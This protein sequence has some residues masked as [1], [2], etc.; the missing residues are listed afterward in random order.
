MERQNEHDGKSG[1]VLPTIHS[2]WLLLSVESIL[3]NLCIRFVTWVASTISLGSGRHA[4]I[5]YYLRIILN[6]SV[7]RENI[8][9]LPSF[10]EVTTR[11]DDSRHTVV[12]V[13]R[14]D[15]CE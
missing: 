11:R 13:Q 6:L 1:I 2:F 4:H 5:M 15:S 10:I 12:L 9:P 8:S 14:Y 7:D 3:H